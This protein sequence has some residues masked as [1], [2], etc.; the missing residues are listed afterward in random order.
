MTT[1]RMTKPVPPKKGERQ[2]AWKMKA[3]EASL[4][5]WEAIN[6]PDRKAKAEIK[7]SMEKVNELRKKP[8]FSKVPPSKVEEETA[9]EEVKARPR[10][11]KAPKIKQRTAKAPKIEQSNGSPRHTVESADQWQRAFEWFNRHLFDGDLPE[12]LIQWDH[13]KKKGLPAFDG[14]FQPKRWGESRGVAELHYI[15]ID[16]VV[17]Y[18]KKDK[19]TLRTLVHEMVHLWVEAIGKGKIKPYHCKRWSAKMVELGLRPIILNSKGIPTPDKETGRYAT[20]ELIKGGL[21]DRAADELISQDFR[22][23][24]T[25][26][27]DPVKEKKPKEKKPPTRVDFLCPD[28]DHKVKDKRESRLLCGHHKNPILMIPD[29]EDPS[30]EEMLDEENVE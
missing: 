30:V 27:P 3:Y 7:T 5:D 14:I 9:E 11:A 26:I 16:P 28:C 22:L 15:G 8:K 25:R 20:D 21:F 10:T 12:V 24:Y 1:V 13:Q 2:Y 19:D 18:T 4:R 6:D 17:H 29:V 23:T